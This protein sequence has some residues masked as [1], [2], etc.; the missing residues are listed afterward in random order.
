M[1]LRDKLINHRALHQSDAV[2]GLKGG[3]DCGAKV[4]LLAIAVSCCETC[5]IAATVRSPESG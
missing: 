4:V 1:R 2:V 3:G 5:I